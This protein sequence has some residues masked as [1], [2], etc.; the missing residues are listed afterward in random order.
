MKYKLSEDHE[1]KLEQFARSTY[2]QLFVE[3]LN[4]RQQQIY[5]QLRLVLPEAFAKEQG[6]LLELDD[7]AATLKIKGLLGE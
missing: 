4:E 2:A 3:I 7:I 6:R 1:R 5:T